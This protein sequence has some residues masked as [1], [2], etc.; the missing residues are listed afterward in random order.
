M[1]QIK[2]RWFNSFLSQ[3]NHELEVSDFLDDLHLR[4]F[5]EAEATSLAPPLLI[6]LLIL[7][8]ISIPLA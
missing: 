8:S 7:A 4:G 6:S 2:S 1:S 3:F 5:F